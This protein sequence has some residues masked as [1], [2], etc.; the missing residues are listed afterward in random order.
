MDIVNRASTTVPNRV[1][2]GDNEKKKKWESWKNLQ[3]LENSE[4]KYIRKECIREFKSFSPHF[5]PQPL[6]EF[7]LILLFFSC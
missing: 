2:I 1:K 3:L 4:F 7:S 5:S 6:A